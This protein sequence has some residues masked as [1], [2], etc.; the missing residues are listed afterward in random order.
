M[1]KRK[2]P[3]KKPLTQEEIWDDSALVQ[4]W[5]DAVEEYNL[6][7]SI[8]ARGESVDE[9]LKAED[10]RIRAEDEA[11][12]GE[13][14]AEGPPH[15]HPVA[16][17]ESVD[18]EA[19]DQDMEMEAGTDS[20]DA[21]QEASSARQNPEAYRTAGGGDR[22]SPSNLKIFKSYKFL[23]SQKLCRDGMLFFDS[24][25]AWEL[26]MHSKLRGS[27][28][29]HHRHISNFTIVRPHQI[30]LNPTKK[31]TSRCKDYANERSGL[32]DIGALRETL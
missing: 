31:G 22:Y 2:R 28:M 1:G 8:Q 25:L 13:H 30:R 11:A 3:K 15:A 12:F 20:H 19:N 17:S 6:Y 32:F 26:A 27:T 16:E 5:D 4:S 10:A 18:E 21:Q 7:H 24:S 23:V 14:A 29:R 9:V